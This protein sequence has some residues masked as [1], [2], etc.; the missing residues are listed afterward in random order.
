MEGL[1]VQ[2]LTQGQS[3]QE[4]SEW[5]WWDIPSTSDTLKDET[6]STMAPSESVAPALL[7]A[8]ACEQRGQLRIAGGPNNSTNQAQIQGFELTHPNVYPQR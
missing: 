4:K 6:C 2:P 8:T 3:A 1:A 5:P 7:S